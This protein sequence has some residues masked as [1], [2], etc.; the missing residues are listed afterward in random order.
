MLRPTALVALAASLPI[1]A[2]GCA[3]TAGAVRPSSSTYVADWAPPVEV[4]HPPFTSG[5]HAN[6][7]QTVGIAY[8]Y[9]EV[10]GDYSRTGAH[11]PMLLDEVR[12]QGLEVAPTTSPFALFFDDPGRTEVQELRSRV[13]IELLGQQTVREPL[14]LATLPGGTAAHACVSGPYP[15]AA[16]AYP[17]L[18]E[19]MRRMNWVRRGP[20]QEI[21]HVAPETVAGDYS[22]LICEIVVPVR[23]GG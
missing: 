17:L 22:R 15:D 16:R 18:F 5:F 12:R 7:L 8:A 2:P 19:Y 14:A 11:I 21:Y 1:L 13:C 6:W 4:S 20:I 10:T 3:S 9:I 23:A